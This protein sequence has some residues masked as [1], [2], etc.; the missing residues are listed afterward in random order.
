MISGLLRAAALLAATSLALVLALLPP[1]A[2]LAQEQPVLLVD[3]AQTANPDLTSVEVSDP[4][5]LGVSG[6]VL[7]APAGYAVSVVAANLGEPRFM[8]FDGSGNLLVAAAGEGVIYRY[9]FTDGLL[10][11]QEALITGLNQP[12]SV[13]LFTDVDTPYLYVSEPDAISRYRYDASGGV[14][15]R[16][17]VISNL[18]TD[19]HHTRTVAF[20]PDG[21]LYLAVGSSCNI[22]AESV[23]LRATVS[24]ANPDGSDLTIMAR[25][26]R[27]P[28]GLAF[29][30]G[31]DLLWATVNE[32]DNQGNEIPPDLVTIVQQGANYGWPNCLPPD[33]TP[34]TP[35]ADC[36]GITPPTI[37]IQA[38]SAPLGLAFLV[39][40]GVPAE[41]DGDL[42]VVQH[43]SWNRQPPAQPKLLLIDF[44]DGQPVAV[45]DLVTGWQDADGSRWGRPAGVVLAPDGSFIVS[46]DQSGVLY[47][48]VPAA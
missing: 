3:D 30:P 8:T 41:L 40:E 14:G 4:S 45:R 6:L 16:E 21:M 20:G 24:R 17:A 38:H 27:N 1:A 48:I 28:V 43:G 39:G 10:S 31:T 46:D 25:G 11:N 32:R 42:L 44:A 18:P 35:G 9:A 7:Q 13:T 23:Q 5:G 36:S 29:Q 34:Q 33:A 22:C 15:E 26:L 47:R 2:S 19:G 12:T 37:G